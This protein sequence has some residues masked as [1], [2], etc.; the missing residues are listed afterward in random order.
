MTKVQLFWLGAT[1]AAVAG[2]ASV[3]V[4]QD[5]PT[6]EAPA[7]SDKRDCG[8]IFVPDHIKEKLRPECE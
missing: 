8:M 5:A 6:P 7:V 4:Q 2:G 3:W 1:F